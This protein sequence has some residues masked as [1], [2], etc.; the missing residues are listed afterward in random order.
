MHVSGSWWGGQRGW[1]ILASCLAILCVFQPYCASLN[2]SVLTAFP[3][4]RVAK[5]QH[6]VHALSNPRCCAAADVNAEDPGA[7][8]SA[9]GAGAGGAGGEPG[10]AGNMTEMMER[11][12]KDPSM[13]KMLYPYLP[14]PMRN[15]SS[16]EWMLSNPEVRCG[17]RPC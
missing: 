4:S 9:G 7:S 2:F 11:M 14:E 15:P 17:P 5:V 1:Y 6:T 10:E 16:I 8:S 13:Q 12:L 3:Q